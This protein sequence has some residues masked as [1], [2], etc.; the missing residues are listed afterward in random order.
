MTEII[1]KTENTVETQNILEETK[2]FNEQEFKSL[3]EAKAQEIKE[4]VE[5]FNEIE[6]NT[7][8]ISL[9]TKIS[10]LDVSFL[11]VSTDAHGS[12]DAM[13]APMLA[14]GAFNF[15]SIRYGYVK[16]GDFLKNDDITLLTREG[17]EKLSD[18][19][20]LEYFPIF[21]LDFSDNNNIFVFNGDA[22]DGGRF[23]IN[24]FLTY[25]NL[26]RKQKKLLK[27]KQLNKQ[28][29]FN[30]GNHELFALFD[31]CGYALGGRSEGML[32]GFAE[33]NMEKYEKSSEEY[34]E[35]KERRQFYFGLIKDIIRQNFDLFDFCISFLINN[36]TVRISHSVILKDI[37]EKIS[38]NLK[39]KNNEILEKCRED[40]FSEYIVQISK[41]EKDNQ[42]SYLELNKAIKNFISYMLNN[43]KID[44]EKYLENLCGLFM[45]SKADCNKDSSKFNINLKGV[46]KGERYE[47]T[48]EEKEEIY[49]I[50]HTIYNKEFFEEV[51]NC[52]VPMDFGASSEY[53]NTFKEKRVEPCPRITVITNDRATIQIPLPVLGLEFEKP[54]TC[55]VTYYDKSNKIVHTSFDIE[56]SLYK[57]PEKF[58][59]KLE[60]K[61]E[62]LNIKLIKENLYESLIQT[63]PA[64]KVSK[65][66]EA[67]SLF[68]AQI[69]TKENP[70]YSLLKKCN[71]SSVKG[72]NQTVENKKEKT[73]GNSI[74]F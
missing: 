6:K 65:Y 5:F 47:L 48:E 26:L 40:K 74:S 2:Y 64:G 63:Q 57:N 45:A 68:T 56:S 70:F 13:L 9:L 50:G 54:K 24:V 53:R 36:K 55:Y 67:K 72:E 12:L 71:K 1:K 58:I 33:N 3:L 38:E 11:K 19:Q 61:L 15:N 34:K 23:S 4:F 32:P 16:I 30:F 46:G 73:Q 69:I 41:C 62:A 66:N 28:F 8:Y 29:C 49:L 37:L 51:S 60:E 17:F 39:D 14:S 52:I 22:L 18:A 10:K 31:M 43:K 21:D 59:N 35:L 44:I 42:V 25:L 27:N 20:K 7:N